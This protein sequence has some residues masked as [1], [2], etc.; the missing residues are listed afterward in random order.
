M[1]HFSQASDIKVGVVGYGGA[2]NMGRAHL[3]QMQAAGMT[4]TAVAEID[5]ERLK[6]ATVDFP[7][8]ETYATVKAMLARS[9]VN[10]IVLITPHN[11]HAPLALK[12]LKAGRH[13]VCEKPLALTTGEVNAMI[14]AA[15]KSGL[16]LST[17]HNRHWDGRILEA[18]RRIRKEKEIGSIVRIE[19]HMGGYGQPKDWWRTSRKISGGILY[20]WGVHLLE[21]ALQL[22]DSPIVEVTGFSHH[23]HWAPLTFWKNDTNEDEGHLTVRF[24]SG[25]WLSLTISSIDSK[26]REGMVEVTGT[27]GSYLMDWGHSRIYAHVGGHIHTTQ[28][29][30]PPDEGQRYYDNVRDHLVKGKPLVITAEWSRRPIHILDLGVRSAKLGHAL[31][32]QYP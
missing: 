19:C 2:F 3:A 18:V 32:A 13:V 27:K 7:G 8:I 28:F 31:P 16:V 10:L 4:P 30:N 25:Q 6:V 24:K 23:G 11:T 1:A 9:K 17:Y 14:A 20:D 5:P 29:P 26:P 21:Y 22:I 15:K 12:C